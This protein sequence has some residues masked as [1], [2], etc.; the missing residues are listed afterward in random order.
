[1]KKDTLLVNLFG[2][3]G[4]GKSTMMAR[5]FSELKF[6]NIDCEM[7]PEYAKD[8]VWEESDNLLRTQQLH[9]L[10]E[11]HRRINRLYGKVQVAITDCPLVN[12]ALFIPSGNQALNILIDEEANNFRH[13]NI[14]LKRVKP[15]NPNG[16]YQTEDQAREMD[17]KLKIILAERGFHFY[18]FESS[19]EGAIELTQFVKA[20]M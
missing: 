17:G 12:F 18:E 6:D 1:M 5:L 15:Y 16:R 14:L 19:R 7:A 20:K 10:G 9:L 3:P 11:Q 2:G 13:V 4:T 8:L